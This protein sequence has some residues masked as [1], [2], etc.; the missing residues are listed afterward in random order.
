M[1]G[2]FLDIKKPEKSIGEVILSC[3]QIFFEI[4][5]TPILTWE[6]LKIL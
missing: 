1:F 2:F 5:A 6:I 4:M 3:N